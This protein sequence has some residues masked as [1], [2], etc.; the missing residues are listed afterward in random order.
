MSVALVDQGALRF[1]QRGIGGGPLGP[2]R[3]DGGRRGTP[4]G[5]GRDELYGET[6]DDDLRAQGGNDLVVDGGPDIDACQVLP[7]DFPGGDTTPI[8]CE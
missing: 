4:R 8:N 2:A 3:R 7:E 6:G 1:R 5:D